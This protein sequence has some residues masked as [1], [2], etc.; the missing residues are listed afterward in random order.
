MDA[1]MLKQSDEG[2]VLMARN[3]GNAAS[4]EGKMKDG[5]HEPDSPVMVTDRD[6]AA[7]RAEKAVNE[8]L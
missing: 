6:I 7:Q 4:G 5:P 2:M 3:L 8:L 1:S